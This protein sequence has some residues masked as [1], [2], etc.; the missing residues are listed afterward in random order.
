MFLLFLSFFSDRYFI[1]FFG[2]LKF[3]HFLSI[4]KNFVWSSRNRYFL[5]IFYSVPFNILFS[6]IFIWT[7][8]NIVNSKEPKNIDDFDAENWWRNP[9]EHVNYGSNVMR[10]KI[11]F[12]YLKREKSIK[13]WWIRRFLHEKPII[14]SKSELQIHGNGYLTRKRE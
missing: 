9:K 4:L 12:L 10:L 3:R 5:L 8:L 14:S 11:C 6:L 13:F 2:F 1:R 7:S